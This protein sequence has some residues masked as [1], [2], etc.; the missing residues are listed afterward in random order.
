MARAVDQRVFCPASNGSPQAGTIDL[1]LAL[2]TDGNTRRHY[3]LRREAQRLGARR[4]AYVNYH[5][6]HFPRPGYWLRPVAE[7]FMRVMPRKLRE[8]PKTF[9][10]DLLLLSKRLLVE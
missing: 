2:L 7:K 9:C 1:A 8:N 4:T 5:L 6:K 10:V 3:R